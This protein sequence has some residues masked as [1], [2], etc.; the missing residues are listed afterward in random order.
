LQRIAALTRAHGGVTLIAGGPIV[1]AYKKRLF[2]EVPELEIAVQG[3]GE[4]ILV[5]LLG[6][7]APDKVPGIFYRDN[8]LV[9]ETAERPNEAEIN[10]LAFP[11]TIT[12]ARV[13][14]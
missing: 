2:D 9:R 5:E 14:C 3:E 11:L 6:G 7:I 13:F 8:G 10:S 12:A 1:K 4:Q